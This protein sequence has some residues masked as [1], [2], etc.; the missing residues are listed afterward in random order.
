MIQWQID[1]FKDLQQVHLAQAAATGALSSAE[2]S[3]P[4]SEVRGSGWEWKA[5]TAQEWWRGATPRLR[6]G[7]AA[8][9]S[10]PTSE[11]RGRGWEDLPHAWGQGRQPGG[12][13]PPPSSCGCVGTGG[14]RGAIPHSRSEGAA[15]SRYPSSKVRSSGCTLLEQPWRDT[16]HPR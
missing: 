4:T 9:R 5:V 12:A 14:P 15:V 3:Y 16:P 7:V 10:Y 13:T 2:R 11:A 1:A 8:K 6:S